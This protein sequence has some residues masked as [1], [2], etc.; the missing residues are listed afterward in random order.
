M[1]KKD[2]N[3]GFPD[4]L[5]SLIRPGET[6]AEFAADIGVSASGLNKWIAGTTEPGLSNL[7]KIAKARNVTVGWL[8]TGV[9]GFDASE[10]AGLEGD[11]VM[12][13]RFP[14]HLSAGSGAEGS[15]AEPSGHV[16]FDV[17]WVR[18]VLNISPSSLAIV[19]VS[20]DSMEPTLHDKDLVLI[21]T[22]AKSIQ[23]DGVYAI[24]DGERLMV[25]R[26]QRLLGGR[27]LVRSD[28]PAYADHELSPE[29]TESIEILGS[30]H[31]RIGEL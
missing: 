28:N 10:V 5:R 24:R 17:A 13:P 1:A 18:T 29:N 6:V 12:I 20:G 14:V 27:I 3:T 31:L 19:E 4:R 8:A 7:I 21:D 15:E 16:A 22:S 26:L 9:D 25:K 30:V 23:A 11:V 2:E